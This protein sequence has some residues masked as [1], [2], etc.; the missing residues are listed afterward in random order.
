SWFGTQDPKPFLSV[1]AFGVMEFADMAKIYPVDDAM[2]A[3]TI[4]W[5]AGQQQSDGSWL[6]D[7]SEF[8]SFQTSTL[9]NTAFVLWALQ[10]AGYTG[11]AIA[12]ALAY[13]TKNSDVDHQDSYTLG[14]LGNA[15]QLAAPSDPVTQAVFTKIEATQQA[16]P[17]GI[18]WSSAGTQTQF[19]GSGA[20]ADVAS[21][22][23]IASAL[24]TRGGYPDLTKGALDY[25][26]SARDPQGNFGSTQ[27]TVW[28]LRALLLA[29]TKGTDAAVG[30]LQISLDDKAFA[31]VDLK[32]DQSDVMS[33]IDLGSSLTG[34]SHAVKLSFTGTGKA[35]YHVV[36]G[37]NLAWADVP[38]DPVG[39]VSVAVAYDKTELT[40][41][42]T[43]M[44]TVSVTNNTPT[45]EN[46]LLVTLGVAP[47]FEVVTD[48]LQPYLTSGVLSRAE[49]T[50]KQLTLY[51][52]TLNGSATQ[53]I[54]YHLRATM[55]ITATDGGGVAYPYYEPSKRSAVA[56]TQ[57]VVHE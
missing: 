34:G 37:Y 24:I 31:T 44:A 35:S 5:L 53:V 30:S 11:P 50:G 47:G 28:T 57:F 26:V 38:T 1:T 55:P 9:R 15:L 29:A 43:V 14:I 46:M 3:R 40:L 51:L 16:V 17:K 21:T 23:L 6:G 2:F 39:P 32:V 25:L 7:T 18:S 33:T 56:S 52:S 13:V 41:N 54:S 36:S 12:P 27:A 45:T 48:D 19:Y 42:D 49:P 10:A 8:F 4:A 20:D 22:A